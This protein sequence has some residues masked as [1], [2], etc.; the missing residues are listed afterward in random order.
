MTAIRKWTIRLFLA[1][2]RDCGSTQDHRSSCR[3]H[4]IFCW[5][6]SNYAPTMKPAKL[7]VGRVYFG[8]AYENDNRA[9]PIVHTYEFLGVETA[10]TLA[11]EKQYVFRFVGSKDSLQVTERQIEHVI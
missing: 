7:K 2:S 11:G 5:L 9:H 6:C 8:L 1:E 3:F 4:D 10:A